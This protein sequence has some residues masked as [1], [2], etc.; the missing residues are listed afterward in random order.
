MSS[1]SSFTRFPNLPLELRLMVWEHAPS[2]Y[3]PPV[4]AAGYHH[5]ASRE[6]MT[7]CSQ[8]ALVP[9]GPVPHLSGLACA[10]RFDTDADATSLESTGSTWTGWSCALTSNPLRWTCS[11]CLMR[12]SSVSSLQHVA[13][14]WNM[15]STGPFYRTGLPASR[16]LLPS[17]SH[18][19]SSTRRGGGLLCRATTEPGHSRPLLYH[20]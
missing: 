20:P 15:S 6:Q 9:V 13:L 17:P 10:L 12:K 18:H 1:P 11:V 8:T 19:N 4:F 14:S 2:G 16:R 7:H 5:A 3:S